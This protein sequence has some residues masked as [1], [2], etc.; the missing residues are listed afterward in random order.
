MIALRRTRLCAVAA[1]FAVTALSACGADPRAETV[2]AGREI[3][4]QLELL[5]LVVTADR[6]EVPPVPSLSVTVRDAADE[7]GAAGQD[8]GKLTDDRARAAL[9]SITD[10]A[11]AVAHRLDDGLGDG[12][13]EGLDRIDAELQGLIGELARWGVTS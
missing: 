7:L 12:T 1:V 4:G 6:D 3:R 2:H 8:V 11:V 5:R 13:D 10:R 9:A